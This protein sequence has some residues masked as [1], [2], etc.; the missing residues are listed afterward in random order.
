MSFPITAF[1]VP[2]QKA[3]KLSPLSARLWAPV[4]LSEK[5]SDGEGGCCG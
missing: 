1:E 2:F 3:L 5:L 4:S